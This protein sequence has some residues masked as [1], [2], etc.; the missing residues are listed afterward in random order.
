MGENQKEGRGVEKM[1]KVFLFLFV[2]ACLGFTFVSPAVPGSFPQWSIF[3]HMDTGNLHPAFW[4]QNYSLQIL[5]ACPPNRAAATGITGKIALISGPTSACDMP[6][7]IAEYQAATE[8]P[9]AYMFFQAV[10]DGGAWF[11]NPYD[12]IPL[13]VPV[14]TIGGSGLT[15]LNDLVPTLPVAVFAPNATIN[16]ELTSRDEFAL[17]FFTAGSG[18][19]HSMYIQIAFSL[20]CMLVSV[21]K[22]SAF[23]SS[24]GIQVNIAQTVLVMS[25]LSNLFLF[26]FGGISGWWHEPSFRWTSTDVEEFFSFWF[27]GFCFTG[28]LILGFYFG[29][30]ASLTS[31]QSVPGLSKMKIPA[32]V[33]I[34]ILWAVVIS[35][36]AVEWADPISR[37]SGQINSDSL[38]AFFFAWLAVVVP[39]IRTAVLV[40]GSVSLI[41]A[42]S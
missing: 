2:P 18:W 38:D 15:V 12:R 5:P 7:I 25:F 37:T 36:G 13:D 33:F 1:M 21:W 14:M 3:D 9:V 10:A 30:I 8:T 19:G 4:G 31:A 35:Y 11:T 6:A 34:F 17:A 16:V 40:W 23:V 39:F 27:L 20:A 24:Q 41:L 28:V 29:E 42:M 22:L 26:V 32:A